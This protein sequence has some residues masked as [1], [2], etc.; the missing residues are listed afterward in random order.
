ML[1]LP[2]RAARDSAAV[3]RSIRYDVA[4]LKESHSGKSSR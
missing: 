4:T 2:H 1:R 3:T